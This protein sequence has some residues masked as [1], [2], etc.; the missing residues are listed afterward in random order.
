MDS[1]TD[2]TAALLKYRCIHPHKTLVMF[3]KK[4]LM[5]LRNT[6]DFLSIHSGRSSRLLPL[7]KYGMLIAT[8]R[9]EEE[10]HAEILQH[11]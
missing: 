1:I 9:S 10:V 8:P 6:R 7:M 2:L 11:S 3:K 4:N 5:S